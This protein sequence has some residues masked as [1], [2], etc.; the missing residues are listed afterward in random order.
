MFNEN[1]QYQS[2]IRKKVF[3]ILKNIKENY[4]WWYLK[5]FW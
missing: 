1:I 2:I 3:R 5:F 4:L